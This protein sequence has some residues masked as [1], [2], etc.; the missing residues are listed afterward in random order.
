[1]TYLP[2]LDKPSIEGIGEVRDEILGNIDYTRRRSAGMNRGGS[3]TPSGTVDK[4]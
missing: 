4:R 3:G 2:R 1:V